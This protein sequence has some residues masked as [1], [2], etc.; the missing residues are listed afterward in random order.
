MRLPDSF[1]KHL[2]SHIDFSS[3]VLLDM[4]VIDGKHSAVFLI[5]RDDDAD[6][7]NLQ[8]NDESRYYGTFHGMMDYSVHFKLISEGYKNSLIKRYSQIKHK[9]GN[10]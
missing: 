9:G 3:F 5:P 4:K 2:R 1:Q 8:I 6:Y 10:D 7:C